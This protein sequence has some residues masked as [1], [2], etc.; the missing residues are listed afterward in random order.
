MMSR[1]NSVCVF[2]RAELRITAHGLGQQL[3]LEDGRVIAR[4]VADM[5]KQF[6]RV[7]LGLAKAWIGQNA[8]RQQPVR[9]CIRAPFQN[10]AA[11]YR[12][13]RFQ[14]ADQGAQIAQFIGYEA[15]V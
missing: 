9:W 3:R 4:I 11:Q 10:T 5:R 15:V 8:V 7:K 2:A 12:L 1:Q 6:G 14:R 13:A